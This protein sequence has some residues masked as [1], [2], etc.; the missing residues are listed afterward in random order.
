MNGV[1]VTEL[2]HTTRS[3]TCRV[4]SW[5]DR[6]SIH[7]F[8]DYCFELQ[9]PHG[10]EASRQD[11]HADNADANCAHAN[12]ADAHK[13]HRNNPNTHKAHWHNSNSNDSTWCYSYCDYLSVKYSAFFLTRLVIC[14]G[15]YLTHFSGLVCL[16][17][18]ICR[19][20]VMEL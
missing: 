17:H 5:P 20:D 8:G 16:F 4:S 14:S 11:P 2:H 3:V 18:V 15:I 12:A 13:A 6:L 10:I 1:G 7:L 19:S 9:R